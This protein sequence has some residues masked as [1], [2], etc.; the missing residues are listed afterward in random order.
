MDRSGKR[1]FVAV[2]SGRPAARLPPKCLIGQTLGV[3]TLAFT[4]HQENQPR[5]RIMTRG[6]W[7]LATWLVTRHGAKAPYAVHTRIMAMRRALAEQERIAFWLRVDDAVRAWA[8][9]PGPADTLH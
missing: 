4:E 1:G 5:L 7:I 8:S 2:D 9:G 6:V 3:A